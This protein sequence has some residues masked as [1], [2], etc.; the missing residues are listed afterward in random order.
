MVNQTKTL[1]FSKPFLEAKYIEN[2]ENYE[3]GNET[4]IINLG[5]NAIKLEGKDLAPFGSSMYSNIILKKAGKIVAIKS[6]EKLYGEN[7]YSHS[8]EITSS[9]QHVHDIFS[10]P[11]LKDTALWRSDKDKVGNIE[12]N[13]WYAKAG[14][15]CGIHNKHDFKELHTQ[16]YGIGRM[17]KFH[18]NDFGTLYQNVFMSPGH[19]H[20]P[21]Y[22][23]NETY[24]WHQYLADTD[25]IWL[26]M[27]IYK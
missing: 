9:W 15:N 27:E 8:K 18:K 2:V 17:Q 23:E 7:S 20:E 14:T 26:A 6:S 13:L 21:F 12:L 1:S 4:I 5:E 3:I 19:T 24:P 11:H 16:I 22:D 10:L 25:C